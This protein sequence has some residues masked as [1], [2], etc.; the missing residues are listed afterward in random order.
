[1]RI[2]VAGEVADEEVIADEVDISS[3]GE[4]FV[5]HR[6]IGTEPR[7]KFSVTHV[8]TGFA[9]AHGET[10]D[11][12]VVAARDI[13]ASNTPQE[14]ISAISYAIAARQARDYAHTHQ[15]GATQ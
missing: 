12:A 7:G 13:W 10:I 8:D 6:S 2:M 15:Q 5:V 3:S 11:D 9:I 4:Q 14:R 1:M